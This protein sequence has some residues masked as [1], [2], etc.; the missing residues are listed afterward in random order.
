[1]EN[2]VWHTKVRAP[3]FELRE[4]E[5]EGRPYYAAR[6]T[7]IGLTS[8]GWSQDEAIDGLH[9]MFSKWLELNRRAVKAEN[10]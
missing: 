8:Y 5:A 9:D 4:T 3:H 2:N 10:V 7:S 6:V 1:M